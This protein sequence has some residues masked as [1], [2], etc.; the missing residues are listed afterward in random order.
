MMWSERLCLPLRTKHLLRH[1]GESMQTHTVCSLLQLH[2]YDPHSLV[3]KCMIIHVHS[4]FLHWCLCCDP[5]VHV[6]TNHSKIQQ[7]GPKAPCCLADRCRF[8]YIASYFYCLDAIWHWNSCLVFYYCWFFP[9]TKRLHT[10]SIAMP[11]LQWLLS[12]VGTPLHCQVSISGD[13]LAERLVQAVGV[14][15]INRVAAWEQL[16]HENDLRQK[17]RLKTKFVLALNA[18]NQDISATCCD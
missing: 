18:G 1:A 8:T 15:A 17:S 3:D 9:H 14:G 6:N 16:H 10:V 13:L 12:L 5:G 11:L 7:G 4:L 2:F